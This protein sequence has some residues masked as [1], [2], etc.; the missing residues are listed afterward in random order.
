MMKIIKEY[1]FRI[2]PN[3]TQV[4]LIDKRFRSCRFIY[5]HFLNM[6][7]NYINKNMKR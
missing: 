1:V 6:S 7:N 4:N 3:K 2:Y 5:N